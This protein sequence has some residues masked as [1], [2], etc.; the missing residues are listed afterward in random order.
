MYKLTKPLIFIAGV[1]LGISLAYFNLPLTHQSSEVSPATE[2]EFQ[3]IFE[4]L[5]LIQDKYARDYDISELIDSANKGLVAGLGD[6]FSYQL[7]AEEFSQLE[8]SLNSTFSGVGI[9]LDQVEGK[10]FVVTPIKD[11]PALAAGIKPGDQIVKVDDEDITD[12]PLDLIISKITGP[13][14]SYVTLS[15]IRGE[16]PLQFEIQRKEIVAPSTNLEYKDGVA[17]LDIDQFARNTANEVS[18]YL[19]E[20][21]LQSSK[22]LIID[23][24][25]N[26]GG[27]LD[28]VVEIADYFLDS[29]VIYSQKGKQSEHSESADK[30]TMVPTDLQIVVLI[31]DHSASAAEILAGALKDNHRATLIGQKTYGKGSVQE[32]IDV[33]DDNYLRLTTALWYTPDGVNIDHEGISPDTTLESDQ[34]SLEYA[35]SHLDD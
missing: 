35:L 10:T 1:V 28:S 17:V 3:P 22:E 29:G 24:R 19:A 4:T 6:D 13:V 7:N 15:L 12:Q 8:A 26:P 34:D 20:P 9:R 27:Y 32:L 25:D 21:E 18:S 5:S 14:D 31:D 16:E 11:S 33:D 2:Q 23:L 30:E